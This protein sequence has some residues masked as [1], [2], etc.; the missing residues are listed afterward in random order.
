[1]KSVSSRE[2]PSAAAIKHTNTQTRTHTN[3]PLPGYIDEGD[4]GDD[5][6]DRHDEGDDEEVEPTVD[7]EPGVGPIDRATTL[8]RMLRTK[9]HE[10][11]QAGSGEDAAEVACQERRRQLATAAESCEAHID[12]KSKYNSLLQFRHFRT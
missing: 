3:D 2:V 10:L 11:E 1:M 8:L 12:G 6:D 9:I 7:L 5:D 4:E